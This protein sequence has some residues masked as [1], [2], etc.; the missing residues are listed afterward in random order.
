M[1]GGILKIVVVQMRFDPRLSMGWKRADALVHA[2]LRP[3]MDRFVVYIYS[4]GVGGIIKIV[5]VHR[6]YDPRSS[7]GWERA[8]AL[9]QALLRPTMDRLVVH[10]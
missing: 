1:R 6:H 2:L 9:V 3:T 8:D 4:V 10:I 7:T 5:V